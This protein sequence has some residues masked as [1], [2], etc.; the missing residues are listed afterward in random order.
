MEWLLIVMTMGYYGPQTVADGGYVKE[1]LCKKAGSEVVLRLSELEVS[2][3]K[4]RTVGNTQAYNAKT[5]RFECI[6][7]RKR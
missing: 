2:E 6:Q 3:E 7:V 1:G 4:R 5:W